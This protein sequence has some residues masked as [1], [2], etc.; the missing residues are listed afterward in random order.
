MNIKIISAGAGS[1][2]TYRLTTELVELLKSGVRAS[3]II[4]TTFTQKAAAE[5]QERVRVRL[6]QDGLTR[7]AD[8]INN[9]LIGT[10]HGLGVKLL[11]RF[12]YEAGVSPQVDIIADEDQQV[13]FNQA[14]ATV[15]PEERVLAI[16]RLADRLGFAQTGFTDWRRE[17]KT[18]TDIARANNFSEEML[19]ESRNRSYQTFSAFLETGV[20]IPLDSM[21]GQL[22]ELLNTAIDRLQNGEDHTVKTKTAVDTLRQ[23]QRELQLREE[24]HWRQWLKIAKMETGAK[25][26]DDIAEL[27]E[28]AS[29]HEK[30]PAF[31]RDIQEFIYHLFDVAIDAL[32]EYEQYKKRR[33]LI[34]YTDMEALVYRLLDH[35][36][37]RQ[38]LTEELDLLMVDEFQDTSP[39]QLALFLRLS[40][41]ARHAVWVGDPKQSIYGF[42]G[43]EPRLMQAI[44]D[45]AGGIKP[46]DIQQFSWRSRQDIVYMTNAVFAKAFAPT[47]VE[48]IALNPKRTGE[49]EPLQAGYAL[50]HWH[51]QVDDDGKNPPSAWTADCIANTL[52]QWLDAGS[53]WVLPKGEKEWRPP[54]PGDVAILCRN[55]AGCQAMAEALHRAGLKAALSR[56]GLLYTAEAKLTLACLKFLLN[57]YDSL[58]VA[59]ILLLAEGLPIEAIIEDR[60]E[61]L[62]QLE[63]QTAASRWAEHNAFINRLN[64]LRAQV[65]ELSAAEILNLLIETLDLRRIIA[66]W[67]NTDQRLDNVE[68]LRRL[69]HQYEEACNRLHSASTLG[70]LLLWLSDLEKTNRDYQGWG[71]NP[72]AVNVLTY[73]KSK[74]LEWPA[75]ICSDLTERLRADLWGAEIVA[76]SPRIDLDNVL[77]GRWLRYWVNPYGDARLNSPLSERLSQS[78]EQALKTRQALQEEARLMYVG[79]TRARD[80]LI[81]PTAY[82]PTS[83]LNRVWH[84]GNEDLP[85]LDPHSS[86]SPWHWEGYFLDTQTDT[87]RYP[88]TFPYASPEATPVN[89]LAPRHGRLPHP[90]FFIDINR[91]D[92]GVNY[93]FS[94]LDAY[95]YASPLPGGHIAEAYQ[96]AKLVKA[97]LL[98]D[99]AEYSDAERQ[100]LAQELIRNM[101]PD[102]PLDAGLLARTGEAWRQWLGSRFAIRQYW[103]KYPLRYF[104]GAQLFDAIAD[105]I[106]DTDAGLVLIQHSSFSGDTKGRE[107]KAQDL[108]PWLGLSKA[109]MESHFQRPVAATLVHFVLTCTLI[110]VDCRLEPPSQQ[111]T[112]L[113]LFQ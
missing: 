87:F 32:R 110:A 48:Q 54:R 64:Q 53:V 72:D 104:Y 89:Y 16:E 26:R 68:M 63:S 59:E 17:V 39:L 76:D 18:I 111:Q 3:G 92:H 81:L 105:L 43:A 52:R 70:G 40:R 1:G 83:W 9:A 57:R 71:E 112:Q 103:R 102:T 85:T 2:K 55:N 109:A 67:G 74:G 5:L 98:A 96:D 22:A 41:F 62:A 61:H 73:H 6:L 79:L 58:A 24:L 20:V 12:A 90:P 101:S 100:A 15:L 36:D 60:L 86:E 19:L 113:E 97:F 35:P 45:H 8:E 99:H 49:G 25:S 7:Q 10:V 23:L 37:V 34:D 27:R 13:M 44:I 14:L 78:L 82:R 108:A 38:V 42:R 56:T 29:L 91:R 69:T 77:E 30:H 66:A 28:W 31:H 93:R 46:E 95:G 107:K 33:G 50:V 106:L 4:A 94:L 75:V 11:R 80:Y 84:D 21:H 88:R 47:P 51:F 65:V